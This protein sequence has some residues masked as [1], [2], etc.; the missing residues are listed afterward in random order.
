MIRKT[1]VF[2]LVGIAIF[3]HNPAKLIA[4]DNEMHVA[5]NPIV[6]REQYVQQLVNVYSVKYGVSGADMMRTLRNENDTFQFDRQSGLKYKQGNRWGFPAGT[7]EK[8][9]GICQIHLPDNPDVSYEQAINPEFCVEFM[10][11]EF[12]KGNQSKWMGYKKTP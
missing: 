11:K 8:S 2:G 6:D 7:Q 10:A 9:Y 4:Y 3:S 1:I 12:A 5:E